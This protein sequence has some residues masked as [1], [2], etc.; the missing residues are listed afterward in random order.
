[1]SDVVSIFNLWPLVP[2]GRSDGNTS[3]RVH[4]S[5]W[6][7]VIDCVTLQELFSL[8]ISALGESSATSLLKSPLQSYFFITN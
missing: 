6:I 4:K 5:L 7:V 2:V 1:M 3:Q 8:V